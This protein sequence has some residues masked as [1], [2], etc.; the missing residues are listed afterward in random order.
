[1]LSV[2]VAGLREAVRAPRTIVCLR[3]MLRPAVVGALLA[4]ALVVSPQ[5][6][7]AQ[8]V[9]QGDKLLGNDGGGAEGISAALSADGNT[10]LAGG[11]NDADATGAAWVY[12]RDNTGT[13]TQQGPKLTGNDSSGQAQ[14]GISV[15]LSA[16]GNTAIV[17]GK[18]DNSAIGAVW[19]YT[20]D[21]NNGTWTQQGPKLTASDAIGNAQFGTSVAL[22]ADGNTAI[23]GG[24]SDDSDIGA[25]WVFIRSNGTWTQQ[26]PKLTGND[27]SGQAEQGGSVALS[28]DGNTAIF[29][30]EFDTGA[31]G[32]AW[33]F[34]RSSGVW[35]QQGGKLVGGNGL[36]LR[37]SSVALSGDGNTAFSGAP[38]SAGGVGRA[39][40]FTR[41][42]GIWT[43]QGSTLVPPPP[44]SNAFGW[45]GA[46]SAD[47]NTLVV[48]APFRG[49]GQA[50]VYT[51]SNGVWHRSSTLAVDE[52]NFP[53]AAELGES[54]A[55]SADGDTVLV[56]GTGY[57]NGD[58]ASW[59]F[60]Q[61]VIVTSVSPGTGSVDGGALVE[62][63]GSHF[64]TA[65]G[66][67]FG[68]IAATA[69]TVV[70]DTLIFATTPPHAAGTVDVRPNS[71]LDVAT[72]MGTYSY[73]IPTGAFV[74]SAAN[75]SAFGQSVALTAFVAGDG[76]TPTGSVIFKDGS[77]TLGGAALSS[78]A[79]S[80]TTSALGAGTHSITAVYGGNGNFN[81]SVSSSL[82]Q[83]VDKGASKS[84]LTATPNPARPGHAVKL[85]AT[86]AAAAPAAG[87]PDGTVT[88]RQGGTML[89]SKTLSGGTASLR[90]A[91]LAIGSDKIT[92]S[93]GGSANWI[94]SSASAVTETVNA[95]LGSQF[96]VNGVDGSTGNAQLPAVATLADGGFVAVWQWRGESQGHTT[97]GFGIS[98]H[99][100][101]NDNSGIYGQRYN[102]NGA[103]NGGEFRITTTANEQTQPSV[104]ALGDGGF[105]VAWTSN[106][107]DGSGL[108]IYAQRY[109]KSGAKS[110]VE[111]EVNSTTTNNQSQPA[112]AGLADGGFVVAW[113]SNKQDGSG[114]GIY[115]QRYTKTS[116]KSGGEFKVNT[117]TTRS[118]QMPSIAALENGGF[119]VVWASNAQA[120]FGYDIDGQLFNKKS[121]KLGGEFLVNTTRA[122]D[123]T[124]P[125]VAASASGFVV[126]WTSAGQDGSGLGVY[127]QRFNVSG[128]KLGGEFRVNTTTA[129]DQSE[130][131][132]ATFAD[133]GF[134]IVW[135]SQGQDGSGNGVYGQGYDTNGN[136]LNSEFLI[137]TTTAKDQWQPRAAALSANGFVVV[138]TAVDP[139]TSLQGIDAQRL[140]IGGL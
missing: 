14:Q 59:V 9:Q 27:S 103:K 60:V 35:T 73:G 105:V 53:S 10:A 46:L 123:Q 120:Q 29:G 89:G 137:N 2:F 108:G 99:E 68:A 94:A 85:T 79:A 36:I 70:D 13:W 51:R 91:A 138:W 38:S 111:I 7:S 106:G 21:S 121:A 31:T 67:T 130:P 140:S 78:G 55:L 52:S 84:T 82:T 75:P 74:T 114:L 100:P 101:G 57:N 127:A 20:R 24:P 116:V 22:S 40:I 58:G 64:T 129:N 107:E 87:I 110:G 126:A 41:D 28:A 32:A 80:L 128:A 86:V 11:S 81:A 1:M 12:I 50:Y 131:A 34:T 15:A 62:I 45:S 98:W 119:V 133:G 102:K 63:T 77:T 23:M 26:G 43:Q 109:N 47:G 65:V 136:P 124:Q 17:G 61:P 96:Q 92:A 18:S 48:G 42:S 56:G 37:G 134:V 33:V 66:V 39:M 44:G 132:V 25:A 90:T 115:A 122:K 117:T 135:T 71:P 88:F 72:S 8:F 125:A 69:M 6:A 83:T 95:R 3:A 54:V 16:D 104:A 113:A 139:T 76:S 93:Y 97:S 118:Q 5:I 49:L 112:V 30:G 19:I 4:A